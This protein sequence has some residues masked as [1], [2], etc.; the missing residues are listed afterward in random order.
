MM[1]G[2]QIIL[3]AQSIQTESTG[4]KIITNSSQT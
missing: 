4:T 1:N 3:E 2:Y